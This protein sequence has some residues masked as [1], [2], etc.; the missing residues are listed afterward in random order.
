ML[1]YFCLEI[2]IHH[3]YTVIILNQ[4]QHNSNKVVP[5]GIFTQKLS[6]LVTYNLS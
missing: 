4:S 1:L 3:Y 5:G 2:I 6:T